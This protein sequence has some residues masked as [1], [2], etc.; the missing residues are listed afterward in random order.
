MFYACAFRFTIYEIS[1]RSVLPRSRRPSRRWC[2]RYDRARAAFIIYIP[3]VFNIDL[4]PGTL[5]ILSIVVIMFV[6][7]VYGVGQRKRVYYVLF[8][9]SMSPKS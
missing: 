8:N 5:I 1:W 6:R 9:F 4:L 7:A 2:C 3:R